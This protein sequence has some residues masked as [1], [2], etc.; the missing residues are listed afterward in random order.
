MK[1][2]VVTTMLGAAALWGIATGALA[3]GKL[4][5]M[6]TMP[7]PGGWSMVL[8]GVGLIAWMIHRRGDKGGM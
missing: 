7:E 1:F 4:M 3:D 5:S 2:K 8:A 6:P